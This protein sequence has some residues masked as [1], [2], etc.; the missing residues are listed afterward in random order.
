[1]LEPRLF[2]PPYY[3]PPPFF[4]FVTLPRYLL[5]YPHQI[6]YLEWQV[7]EWG[8][9]FSDSQFFLSVATRLVESPFFTPPP[10]LHAF[11]PVTESPFFLLS[12]VVRNGRCRPLFQRPS[13]FISLYPIWFKNRP[14]FFP[15]FKPKS[16]P[17]QSHLMRYPLSLSFC[18]GRNGEVVRFV[19]FPL[20][21]APSLP[22]GSPH[23]WIPRF[24]FF[25]LSLLTIPL[26]RPFFFFRPPILGASYPHTANIAFFSFPLFLEWRYPRGV[27][28]PLLLLG[29]PRLF[30]FFSFLG[31]A[32]PCV[33]PN[34][35]FGWKVTPFSR[36]PHERRGLLFSFFPK[37]N[38]LVFFPSPTL[39]CAP[40]LLIC[41]SCQ[42]F[43]ECV[44][45]AP[46][47]RGS[48][49]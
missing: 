30:F 45:W 5:S 47:W 35:S 8:G 34:F 36:P 16:V 12:D 43:V 9:V 13:S 46:F 14:L 7:L 20:V 18:P 3:H 25:F 49:C 28:C 40:V 29:G 2:S 33:F 39:S 11:L 24:V 32:Q 38:T 41:P 27:F 21:D 19:T 23:S 44:D 15:I 1:M 17:F 31:S 22:R 10:P 37:G 4:P 26:V 6:W 48:R 42:C